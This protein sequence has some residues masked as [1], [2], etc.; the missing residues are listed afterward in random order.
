MRAEVPLCRSPAPR[1]LYQTLAYIVLLD[2]SPLKFCLTN[3]YDKSFI[4]AV[5]RSMLIEGEPN[6][7]VHISFERQ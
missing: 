7:G 1:R 5:A 3:K 4:S 6:I 2:P